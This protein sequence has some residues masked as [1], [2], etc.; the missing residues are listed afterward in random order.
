MHP[1]QR[2]RIHQQQ[3]VRG[4]ASNG[5][6]CEFFNLLTSPN[7]LRENGTDLFYP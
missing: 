7:F 3:R 2:T 4:G 6:S 5:N 1:N